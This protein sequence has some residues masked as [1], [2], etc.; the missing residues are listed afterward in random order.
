M[1]GSF[2]IGTQQWQ[3][4]SRLAASVCDKVLAAGGTADDALR[5]FEIPP[6][7]V[8]NTGWQHARQIIAMRLCLRVH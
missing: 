7:K 2:E 4:A 8:D 6:A 1:M 5:L 3:H